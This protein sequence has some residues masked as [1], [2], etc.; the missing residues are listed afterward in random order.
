MVQQ[1]FFSIAFPTILMKKTILL[2]QVH[3]Y[4]IHNFCRFFFVQVVRFRCERET[5][6]FCCFSKNKIVAIKSFYELSMDPKSHYLNHMDLLIANSYSRLLCLEKNT[7]LVRF[8]KVLLNQ[9]CQRWLLR[10]INLFILCSCQGQQIEYEE[11]FIHLHKHRNACCLGDYHCNI[12]HIH[13]KYEASLCPIN[14]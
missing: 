1:S 4:P 13:R 11:S 7:I 9:S 12:A 3:P 2:N 10:K 5:L 14:T 8:G 6:L